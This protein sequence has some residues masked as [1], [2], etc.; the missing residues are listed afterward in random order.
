MNIQ[1]VSVSL[2]PQSNTEVNNVSR[3]ARPIAPSSQEKAQPESPVSE[4]QLKAATKS[5]QDYIKPFNSTLEFSV[6]KDTDKFITK[7]ID[8]TT[9]EVIRQIPSEEMLTIAKALD[10]IKGLFIK[11]SA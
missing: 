10:S 1:S 3:E 8:S 4:E 2:P 6:D 9:K 7:V 5:V 11:Q